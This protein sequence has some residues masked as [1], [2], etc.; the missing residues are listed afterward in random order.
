VDGI[1]AED[2][3]LRKPITTEWAGLQD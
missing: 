3:E 2:S 1:G